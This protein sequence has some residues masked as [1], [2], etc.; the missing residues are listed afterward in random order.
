MKGKGEFIT[1]CIAIAKGVSVQTG[2][3]LEEE[4]TLAVSDDTRLWEYNHQPGDSCGTKM[5]W[6]LLIWELRWAVGAGL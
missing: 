4:E 5:V 3:R 1:I 2:Q 6:G